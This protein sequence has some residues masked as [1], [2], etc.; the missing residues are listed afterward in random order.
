M[1]MWHDQYLSGVHLSVSNK[2]NHSL[3]WDYSRNTTKY[4]QNNIHSVCFHSSINIGDPSFPR[5]RIFIDLYLF[6][7]SSKVDIWVS[8][9]RCP[10]AGPSNKTKHLL[11]LQKKPLKTEIIFYEKEYKNV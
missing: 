6:I 9:R 10:G 5:V 8:T 4:G 3:L 7:K 2:G 1:N 11:E